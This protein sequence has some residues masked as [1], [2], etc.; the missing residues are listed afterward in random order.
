VI[1]LDTHA[2]LWLAIEPNRLSKTAATTI[3]TAVGSGGI[4][5][6]SITLVEAA[7]LMRRGRLRLHGSSEQLLD[8]L[9]DTTGVVIRE[10]TPL[11]ATLCVQLPEEFGRDPADRIIAATAHAESA[12]LVTRDRR[13]RANRL[14][15]TVW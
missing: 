3:R 10:I 4:A 7:W 13:L 12:P 6:A 14:I 8:E 15:E 9:V 5:I 2:W 11:I 1:V